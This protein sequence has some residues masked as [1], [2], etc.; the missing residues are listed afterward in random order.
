MTGTSS[1]TPVSSPSAVT[2]PGIGDVTQVSTSGQHTCAVRGG[3]GYCWGRNDY[4]QL[5]NGRPTADLATP[6]LGFPNPLY[7]SPG[8]VQFSLNANYGCALGKLGNGGT[9]YN[10]GCWGHNTDGNLGNNTLTDNYNA[11]ANVIFGGT[12]INPGAGA[13]GGARAGGRGG[14]GGGAGPAAGC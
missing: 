5:G 4:G 12:N 9:T 7:Y 13:A 3:A 8:V 6:T 10:V 11:I 1:I 2:L 14:G